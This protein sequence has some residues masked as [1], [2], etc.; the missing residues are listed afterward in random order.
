M[1]QEDIVEIVKL[2]AANAKLL[3]ALEKAEFL[4][5]SVRIEIVAED[6]DKANDAAAKGE[7]L[8]CEAIEEARK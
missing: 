6:Y 8:C 2:E 1:C 5:G 7:S 4:F 3:G